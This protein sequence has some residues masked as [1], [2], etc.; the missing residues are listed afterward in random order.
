MVV[1]IPWS[2][3]WT[4]PSELGSFR[5]LATDHVLTRAGMNTPQFINIGFREVIIYS[6]TSNVTASDFP[7]WLIVGDETTYGR[8]N[9]PWVCLL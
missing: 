7:W 1:D 2:V 6:M 5:I 9:Y 3:Y 8:D 4:V